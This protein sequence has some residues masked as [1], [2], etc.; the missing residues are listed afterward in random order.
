ME[1]NP[2]VLQFGVEFLVRNFLTE[3]FEMRINIET[4]GKRITDKDV[5]ALYIILNGLNTGSKRMEKAHL[6]YFA[7]ILGYKLVPKNDS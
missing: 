1:T 2:I 5:R 6:D 3:G 7:D 4:K